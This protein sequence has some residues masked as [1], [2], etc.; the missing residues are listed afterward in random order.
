MINL[1][2]LI[3][4]QDKFREGFP[5]LDFAG[6]YSLHTS[7]EPILVIDPIH[8]ADVY[9]SNDDDASYLRTHGVIIMDFGGDVSCPIWWQ[10]P[11]VL[12]PIS[13]HLSAESLKP[14]EGAIVLANEIGTDS[15]SFIFLPLQDNLPYTLKVQADKAVIQ[16]N[17][18]L[19]RLPAGE[20]EVFYEQWDPPE[21]RLKALYRNIVLKW[22]PA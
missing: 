17:G 10:H 5:E 3:V 22:G 13:M 1:S 7:G 19:L 4:P 9:N 21:E 15:G 14:P 8:L 6:L 12:L 18:V 20:W 16:N 2:R 11:F